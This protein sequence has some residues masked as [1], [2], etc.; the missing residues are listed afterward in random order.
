MRPYEVM[1]ILDPTL[2]DDVI[3]AEVDKA[4]EVIRANGGTPGR[5]DRWGRRKLAYEI[6][7]QMEG[8]YVL[9]EAS[10]EPAVMAQLDR[11]LQL[12]DPVMRHKVMRV[13]DAATRL[14]AAAATS[15]SSS[16]IEGAPESVAAVGAETTG[17]ESKGE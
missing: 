1:I 8:Y 16:A 7:R 9:M 2:E 11:S 6:R 14:A 12:A 17:S 3:Q 5:V 4:T 13:P 10:A 15:P